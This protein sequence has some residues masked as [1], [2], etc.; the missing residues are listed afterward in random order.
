MAHPAPVAD[1]ALRDGSTVQVRPATAA[2]QPALDAF[3]SGLSEESRTFRFFGPGQDLGWAA[4]RFSHPGP[5]THSLVAVHGSPEG[6]VAHGYC[7][8]T[9][10]GVAEMAL[11]VADAYQGRGLGTALLGRLAGLAAGDGIETFEAEVMAANHRMLDVLRESGFPLRTSPS[12]GV[13]HV[14]FPTSLTPEARD[15]FERRE[16][17]SAIA[18]LSAFLRPE[19]VA[20][21]GAS[22]RRGTVGGELFHNLLT[23]GFPGP[24][25]PVSP[26]PVVQSVPAY[27]DVGALPRRVDLAVVA[28]PA[29]QVPD[30]A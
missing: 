19:A 23:S 6:I 14:E 11:A 8:P 29:A 26:H 7:A 30:V 3:L 20:V 17:L 18:A 27:P 5:G 24:V 1:L 10:Q 9:R 22:R 12:A 13:I 28:V 25:Y 15:R 21:V 16:Q 4:E 2:D